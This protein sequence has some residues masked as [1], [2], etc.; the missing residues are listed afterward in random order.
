LFYGI[1]LANLNM[2]FTLELCEIPK[3][4][5]LC[6]KRSGTNYPVAQGSILEGP[7]P[8]NYMKH[9]HTHTHDA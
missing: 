4:Q 9:T 1:Q 5:L 8:H 2:I 3:R 7:R 6:L